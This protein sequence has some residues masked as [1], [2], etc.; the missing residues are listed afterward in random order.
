MSKYI[1]VDLLR[2]E[3]ERQRQFIEEL[4]TEGDN[5]FYDG[6]D[7]AYCYILTF[8]TFLDS[9]QEQPVEGLE[10]TAEE[11][12]RES[13]RKSVLPNIDGPMPEYGGSIK[14]AFIAGAEWMKAKML[15]LIE[16]RISEI[17]GDAQPNPVLRIELQS[18][19]D[20]IK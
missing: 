4:F 18:I 1:D 8:L 15:K 10:E 3:I 19:I 5:S 11:Y 16:T 17:I 12:R 2:K 7:D 20:K 9:I 14:D 6:Q 13:Y